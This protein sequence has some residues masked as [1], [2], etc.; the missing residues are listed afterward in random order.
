MSKVLPT[1]VFALEKKNKSEY[2]VIIFGNEDNEEN[3]SSLEIGGE[4]HVFERKHELSKFLTMRGMRFHR[5][6][7]L[8]GKCLLETDD[9]RTCLVMRGYPMALDVRVS[10]Q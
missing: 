10:V 1:K 2:H 8:A 6:A 4:C 3:K 5:N 9:G 7:V